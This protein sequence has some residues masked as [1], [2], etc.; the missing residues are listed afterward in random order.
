MMVNLTKLAPCLPAIVP[1]L[2][3]PTGLLGKG[4]SFGNDIRPIF[5][6][7]CFQCHGPDAADRKAS[8]RL[9][10][11]SEEVDWALVIQKVAS[12]DPDERMPPPKT[13]K[14]LDPA[15]IRL[16]GKW[17]DAGAEYEV[18]WAF[19]P[20]QGG[21]YNKLDDYVLS[22]LGKKGLGLSKPAPKDVLIRRVTMD[23][24]GLPPTWK[25]VQDFVN[26]ESPDAYGKVIDR[27]LASKGYG[28]RWGR[29]WLDLARYADTHGGS[30]IGFKRFP[31]S[32][33]YRDY[34]IQAFNKD[35][36]YDRFILE[37]IAADQLGLPEDDPAL[38]GLGFLTVGRKFRNRN[39]RLDDRIDV[40]TRG[41]QGLTVACARC[42][43][44][45]FDPI[46]TKD[47]YSM[48]AALANSRVPNELPLTGKPKPNQGY[49]DKLAELKVKR[50]DMIREQ[51]EV[52]RGRLRMQTGLYFHKLARGDPEEDTST[53][54]LSYRTEDYR[55]V[56][57]EK[58][59]KYI[60]ARS[61]EDPVFGPWHQ[62]SGL[63]KDG[64]GEQCQELLAK[65]KKG[66]GDPSNYAKEHS[67][68][69]KPPKW[70]PRILD[71][72]VQAKPKSFIEVAEVYGSVFTG[73][74]RRWLKSLLSAMEEAAPGGKIIPDQDARHKVVNSSIERQ[75]RHHLH[76]PDSPTSITFEDYRELGI[77]NR[78]VRDTVSGTVRAIT[79][80]DQGGNAP[81][82][83]MVLRE[84]EGPTEDFVFIRGNAIARGERV[85]PGYLSILPGEP[86]NFKD[87]QRRLG[88]AQSIVAPS[89][90]LTR[91]V[92]AN[93]VW[94]HHFGKGLVRTPDDFGT[95]SVPPSHPA[96]L[97]F[98]AT[99]L[100]EDGWSLKQLHKHIL[101][102]QTYRQSSTSNPDG[103]SLDPE[104][105]LLWRMPP[106]RISMEAM[107]DS[108]YFV[109]G[110][111]DRRM[112]GK[113]FGEL[114]KEIARRSIYAFLN[115]D[116]ISRM[117]TTF[118]GADPSACTVKRPETLVPQQT[119][120]A[121]NS[122]F[123]LNR[124]RALA[125][126]QELRSSKTSEGKLSKLYQRVYSRNPDAS[127]TALAMEYLQTAENQDA[128]W[129]QIAHALLASNEFH[130]VD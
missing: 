3:A 90:P 69:T 101:L 112:G 88:L 41:L 65:L 78:G 7:N 16:L 84:F 9:D 46:P 23:L 106:Q 36:P 35:V 128:A 97:D 87:G 21:K 86:P 110:E 33:T 116:V 118:N 40:I 15:Q 25:E 2:G 79:S 54:F 80:L 47:Y 103:L 125:K 13:G 27:L 72:L 85:Y 71:A 76:S 49:W 92:I 59:R 18:H 114:D 94:Q 34:V 104:N 93:W 82:R 19:R 73:V 108:M 30:A 57:L 42:H 68:A 39:D 77:L 74:Q 5:A 123:I 61:K 38:A 56:V 95:R 115:R 55:P 11:E 37:Q 52:F 29:H 32:Y 70:N 66:N 107:R 119:L 98:L 63:P 8:L 130:F 28:E 91:R 50:D 26:D 45:K 124:S 58:W 31:F 53:T 117:A 62:L 100:L 121:L 67:L 64:F 4:V 81:A 17:V 6:E 111:L 96:L 12:D 24:T 20:I 14:S 126:L 10:V 105:T 48:H 122:T 75:L 1:L 109:S 89:N 99:Q 120:F 113:P 60:T 129:E 83:S 127:E 43:D 22:R 44:H 102:S 51:G